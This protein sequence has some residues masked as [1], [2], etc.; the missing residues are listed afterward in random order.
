MILSGS[1]L[2]HRRDRCQEVQLLDGRHEA[3]EAVGWGGRNGRPK[4]RGRVMRATTGVT[5]LAFA[6]ALTLTATNVS[7][8]SPANMAALRGL[9]PVSML[10]GTAAGK[11]A[12]AANLAITGAIQTGFLEQPILLAFPAQQQQSLLDAFITAGNATELADGLG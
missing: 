4:L 1:G 3:L 9:V 6:A 12:L 8:Q 5:A 10:T 11:A 2:S 7:A